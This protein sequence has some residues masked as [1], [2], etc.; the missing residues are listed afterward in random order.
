MKPLPS[1]DSK[2]PTVAK[3][4]VQTPDLV[5]Y[6]L[7]PKFPLLMHCS[8]PKYEAENGRLEAAKVTAVKPLPFPYNT[9]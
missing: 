7:E 6:C 4:A 1:L 8:P 9:P 5:M 3:S 2:R